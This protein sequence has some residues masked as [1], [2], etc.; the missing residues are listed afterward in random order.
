MST[1]ASMILST[2]PDRSESVWHPHCCALSEQRV[3]CR[4]CS[5][6]SGWAAAGYVHILVAPSRQADVGEFH[7]T[8]QRQDFEHTSSPGFRCGPG[9]SCHEAASEVKAASY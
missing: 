6:L 3:V 8:R 7:T 5:D 9:R 1:A 4:E 2:R